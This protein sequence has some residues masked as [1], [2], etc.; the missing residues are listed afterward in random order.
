MEIKVDILPEK[1]DS[2]SSIFDK[3]CDVFG[4]HVFATPKTPKDKVLYAGNVIAEY[5]DNDGDGEV[6]NPLVLKSMLSLPKMWKPG[7]EP[8]EQEKEKWKNIRLQSAIYMSADANDSESMRNRLR[9]IPLIES[10]PYIRQIEQVIH[11]GGQ[12]LYASETGNNLKNVNGDDMFDASLE[13]ILHL[14]S[15][16]G[17]ANAYPK[18][19][20]ENKDS[21]IAKL[22]DK[23]RGGR[24][25]EVPD[26]YPN[27]AWYTYKDTTCDYRCQITEYFYWG[28]LTQL[29]ADWKHRINGDL[30]NEWRIKKQDG[31]LMTLKERDSEL[32]N[33]LT[34]KKFLLPTVLPTGNYNPNRKKTYLQKNEIQT[35]Y[36]KAYNKIYSTWGSTFDVVQNEKGR[37]ILLNMYDKI[38]KDFNGE[39]EITYKMT[40]PFYKGTSSSYNQQ[41][42]TANAAEDARKKAAAAQAAKKE[43]EAAAAAEEAKKY[44]TEIFK[45]SKADIYTDIAYSYRAENYETFKYEIVNFYEKAMNLNKNNWRTL[46]YYG[47]YQAKIGK[48]NE[49]KRFLRELKKYITDNN[50]TYAN[51]NDNWYPVVKD[52]ENE[53]K[54]G[55]EKMIKK[56]T[57]GPAWTRNEIEKPQGERDMGGWISYVYTEEQQQR[58]NVDEYGKQLD[59]NTQI[60]LLLKRMNDSIVENIKSGENIERLKEII[61]A[62]KKITRNANVDVDITIDIDE[63]LKYTEIKNKE[64]FVF[65]TNTTTEQMNSLNM[66][67]DFVIV[68]GG[69]SGIMCA[70]RLSKLNPEKKILILEKNKNTHVDYKEAGYNEIKKWINA[71]GDARFTTAFDSMIYDICK[72]KVEIQ[73]GNGLGGGT[74]HFG[75]QYIDQLEVLKRDSWEF[76][77]NEYIDILNDI[78]DICQTK[79]YDYTDDTFPL[80]LKELKTMLETNSNEKYDVYNNKIYSRDLKTRFSL[81]ELLLERNNI[82]VWYDKNVKRISYDIAELE[83]NKITHV[84]RI[85]FFKGDVNL[86]VSKKTQTILCAG[87]IS[88]PTILQRSAICL[89]DYIKDIIPNIELPVGNKLYD[90]AGISLTY[91]HRDYIPKPQP[92]ESEKI[93]PK[94]EENAML[95][96]KKLQLNKANLKLLEPIFKGVFLAEGNNI[97]EQDK[98][99]VWD[100]NNWS[101][102]HP[103]GKTNI[104]KAK[105]TNFILQYPHD[106]GRWNTHKS[107]FIKIGKFNSSIDFDDFPEYMKINPKFKLFF[108]K[109][110]V[111][112]VSRQLL[113]KDD[114]KNTTKNIGEIDSNVIGHI[115]TR[116]LNNDW[117]TYYSLIP[118]NTTNKLLP[119]LIT[120]FATSGKIHNDGYVKILNLDDSN[121]LVYYDYPH[122]DN[123]N[124]LVEAFIDNHE[125]ISSNNNKEYPGEYI[126]TDP[127]LNVYVATNDKENIKKYFK[128][129]LT[130]IY[131]YH[132]TCPLNEVVDYFQ[133]VIN[134]S[135]LKIGD[136]SILTSPIAGSTSVAAMCCGYRCANFLSP[137]DIRYSTNKEL[138][139]KELIKIN[140]KKKNIKAKTLIP[141]RSDNPIK[142]RKKNEDFILTYNIVNDDIIFTLNSDNEHGLYCNKNNIV[143]KDGKIKINRK[144]MTEDMEFYVW[145]KNKLSFNRNYIGN[146]DCCLCIDNSLT[147]SNKNRGIIRSYAGVRW[148]PKSEHQ[149]LPH[150][151]QSILGRAVWANRKLYYILTTNYGEWTDNEKKLIKHAFSQYERVSELTFTETTNWNLADIEIVRENINQMNNKIVGSSYGPSFYGAEVK[152]Y[153]G[154]YKSNSYSGYP[155]GGYIGGWDYATFIHEIGHSLGLMHPHERVEGS[156]VMEN[157]SYNPMTGRFSTNNKANAFPFTVMSYNDITSAY[158]PNFTLKYGFMTSLGPIDIAAI[159]SVYGI[160]KNYNNGDNVYNLINISQNETGWES[161]Y[162]TGGIDEI[163]AETAKSNVVINLQDSNITKKDG[164]GLEIS[165]ISKIWGGYTIVSGSEIENAISGDFNDI[166]VENKLNNI[167]DGKNGIDTVYTLDVQSNYLL[168]KNVDKT[169]SLINVKNDNETNILKNI[170]V[171]VYANAP[172]NIAQK[173][174]EFKDDFILPDSGKGAR[175][176]IEKK[177]A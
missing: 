78:N 152:I 85:V 93:A 103:G 106:M 6:D 9:Q 42:A 172:S 63:T 92:V 171:I 118:D 26:T 131:H 1:F 98:N 170:E 88:T 137:E 22:M 45:F 123:L 75:L 113:D 147:N 20:G 168:F 16:N 160:N 83:K 4:I 166:I 164:S 87:A 116:V 155:K 5:L 35:E 175:I 145:E 51:K 110:S 177:S 138:N 62:T 38:P 64:K 52:F 101:T 77:N 61:I 71:T 39:I 130:S 136:L 12:D 151:V 25:E 100:F 67:Y 44:K 13:E 129:R 53:I 146:H 122:D 127:S 134:L 126:L 76:S 156:I 90:H 163:N 27:D 49:A 55:E 121:P 68:G 91:L 153:T 70:Y 34:N 95:K 11:G 119:M 33:L 161:I 105:H 29:N 158:T 66:D 94:L 18:I 40:K 23:A 89:K 125:A 142:I 173:L 176:V 174:S 162:D 165:K 128:S 154:A 115:Q 65:L 102:Q 3:Y 84:K 141:F 50:E 167:I 41:I 80:V 60:N 14:I 159:Q 21:E 148:M 43:A 96:R 59:I 107:K 81:Y 58:L 2:V 79:R 82:T 120:T 157:V 139:E 57:L 133:G 124:Y 47:I 99:Y 114:K 24:F 143:I 72:N 140:S 31:S 48:L 32:H 108:E 86:N 97:P 28:L 46:Q 10:E 69:P 104:L 149:R 74:L 117:Q 112:N 56:R 150:L 37:E 7:D 169:L 111:E 109:N 30:V 36:E 73:L 54:K 15:S 135:N 17:Y 132:G 144:E 19:F 8:S